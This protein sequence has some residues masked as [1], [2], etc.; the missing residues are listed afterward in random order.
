MAQR[1]FAT[2]DGN[3]TTSIVTSRD[4]LYSD[5]DLS[6]AK[7]PSGD[8]YKK[9]DAAA[10]KQAVKNLLM[11]NNY[12]KP[13]NPTYGGNLSGL[14]FQL[15]SD[16]VVRY[17]IKNN[18]IEQINTFEPRANVSN[19]L[20]QMDPDNNSVEVQVYFTVISTNE[21]VNIQTVISRL[22]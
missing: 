17:D 16:P 3:L 8:I 5:I 2:E 18:I 1:V 9:S 20:V 15:A 11:T 4:K 13:F 21:E 12:E 14:L 6:F 7:R 10:V 19:V 22:R